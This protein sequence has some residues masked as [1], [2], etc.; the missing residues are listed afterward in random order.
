MIEERLDI[1]QRPPATRSVRGR[2]RTARRRPLIEN[3][4]VKRGYR[5]SGVGVALVRACEGAVRLWAGGR[6]EI[7]SQVDED[8]VDAYNLF[9]KCGY[10]C[11]YADRTCT[12]VVLDDVL[13]AKEVPVTKQMM[14]KMLNDQVSLDK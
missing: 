7:F 12:R 4:C 5:R 6:D 2:S 11:L 13:F 10:T 9:R 14:R 3:L 8:N 1:S